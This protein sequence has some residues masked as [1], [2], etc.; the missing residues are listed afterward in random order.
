[1]SA[2]PLAP[3]RAEIDEID[4]KILSLL[5]RRYEI[6]REVAAFKIKNR[7]PMM[8]YDRIKNQ[9]QMHRATAKRHQLREDFISALFKLTITEGNRTEGEIMGVP[10]E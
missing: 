7:I 6:C 4:E 2:H 1:M 5:S 9:M 8:Q 10:W 3:F